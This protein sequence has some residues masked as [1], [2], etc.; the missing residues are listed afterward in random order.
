M[1]GAG[2]GTGRITFGTG[3]SP[4]DV[5]LM[6]RRTATGFALRRR[7]TGTSPVALVP[8]RSATGVYGRPIVAAASPA[9]V[10]VD[11]AVLADV[12]EE[13]ATRGRNWVTA[14]CR[15]RSTLTHDD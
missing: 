2:S 14:R 10:Q 6:P 4:S 7:A 9:E 5:P 1:D 11:V 13:P 15:S 3:S 8:R 12:E